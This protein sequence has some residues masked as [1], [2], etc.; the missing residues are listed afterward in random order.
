[1]QRSLDFLNFFFLFS[2]FNRN[3]SDNRD[4]YFSNEDLNML[5]NKYPEWAEPDNVKPDNKGNIKHLFDGS[6]K[7]KK[8]KYISKIQVGKLNG[9]ARIRWKEGEVIGHGSFGRVVSGLNLSTGEIMAVKQVHIGGLQ[10]PAAK[11]V[12]IAFRKGRFIH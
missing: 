12:R 3:V 5:V 7:H 11:E 9:I 1:M 10:S 6:K 4:G 2:I 8:I